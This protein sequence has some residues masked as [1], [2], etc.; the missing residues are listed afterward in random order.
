MPIL[1]L[2]L[3]V[4]SGKDVP[5]FEVVVLRPPKNIRKRRLGL[6]ADGV[7]Q[8]LLLDIEDLHSPVLAG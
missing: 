8:T 3:S 6:I 7:S 2:S 1:D 4:G 5:S